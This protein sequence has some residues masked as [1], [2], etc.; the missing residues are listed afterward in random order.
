MQLAQKKFNPMLGD[1]KEKICAD[2]LMVDTAQT[3][4]SYGD[5]NGKFIAET[6]L[7]YCGVDVRR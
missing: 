7:K 2:L 3:L 1:E 5:K 6:L 4:Y